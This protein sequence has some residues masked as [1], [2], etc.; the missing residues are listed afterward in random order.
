MPD[1]RQYFACLPKS[2]L[3]THARAHTNQQAA[4]RRNL[5]SMARVRWCVYIYVWVCMLID[6]YLTLMASSCGCR[7]LFSLRLFLFFQQ[8]FIIAYMYVIYYCLLYV[9]LF[10]YV[11]LWTFVFWLQRCQS[12][13][14]APPLGK[15]V[16]DTNCDY[17]ASTIFEFAKEFT[18]VCGIILLARQR[19][20]KTFFI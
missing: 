16:I 2:T 11:C 4:K 3:H 18:V 12:N 1:L 15:Q 9:F 20:S 8:W 7:I 10:V 5:N 6:M 13:W 14:L 19:N 17:M